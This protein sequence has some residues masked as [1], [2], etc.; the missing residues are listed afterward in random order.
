MCT[1]TNSSIAGTKNCRYSIFY[2]VTKRTTNRQ[3][4]QNRLKLGRKRF[5]NRKAILCP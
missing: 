5:R 4:T 2:A 1:I 3:K